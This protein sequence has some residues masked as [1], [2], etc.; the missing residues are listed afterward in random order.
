M[1]IIHD[2]ALCV[3]RED[4]LLFGGSAACQCRGCSTHAGFTPRGVVYHI[5]CCLPLRGGFGSGLF[6]LCESHPAMGCLADKLLFM[7]L[8]SHGLYSF[9]LYEIPRAIY[10][11]FICRGSAPAPLV[12]K[13]EL[14]HVRAREQKPL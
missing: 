5:N 7:G 14:H 1:Y 2:L 3:K 9:F 12:Y 11:F 6:N 13:W 10:F 4:K 8:N